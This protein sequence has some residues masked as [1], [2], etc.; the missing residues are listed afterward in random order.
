MK[1]QNFKIET[2]I[3][4]QEYDTKVSTKFVL[5]KLKKPTQIKKK[6]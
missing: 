4:V 6:K 5:K 3:K 2:K 1:T